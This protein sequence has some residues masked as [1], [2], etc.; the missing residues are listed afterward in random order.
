[1]PAAGMS[2]RLIPNAKMQNSTKPITCFMIYLGIMSALKL[3]GT[4][5][6]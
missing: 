1:M 2:N 6:V 3:A 5:M 4:T